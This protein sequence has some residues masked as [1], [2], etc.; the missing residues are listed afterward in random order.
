VSVRAPVL[1][2]TAGTRRA[3]VSRCAQTCYDYTV[4]VLFN[5]YAPELWRRF[6]L[7]FQR[8][9]AKSAGPH[10]KELR[11]VLVVSFANLPRLNRDPYVVAA[12]APLA[13]MVCLM[14]ASVSNTDDRRWQCRKRTV[15]CCH[16]CRHKK[17]PRREV[18]GLFLQ[19][20]CGGQGRGRTAD[21]PL[22]RSDNHPGRRVHAEVD[23][24]RCVPVAVHGCRRCRHRCR[25]SHRRY[26]RSAWFGDSGSRLHSSESRTGSLGRATTRQVGGV[27]TF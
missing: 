19:V 23:G 22:F 13:E 7:A 5:A 16:R 26:P 9:V 25:Q 6:V 10:A 27:I 14:R 15:V 2:A 8:H 18:S 21:L 3:W 20:S 1:P 24:G 4:S 17:A 11:D 12:T